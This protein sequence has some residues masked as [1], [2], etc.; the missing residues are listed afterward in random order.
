MMYHLFISAVCECVSKDGCA[1]V[2]NVEDGSQQV[3]T[4]RDDQDDDEG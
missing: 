4:A 1:F 2:W 3:N